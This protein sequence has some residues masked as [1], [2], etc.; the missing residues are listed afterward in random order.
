M[1]RELVRA[2]V[3]AC[4]SV[5]PAGVSVYRWKGRIERARE[6]LLVMKTTRAMVG[7]LRRAL[8]A[9]HPYEVPEF[10]V[11]SVAGGEGRYLSWVAES[12]LPGRR[13]PSASPRPGRPRPRTRR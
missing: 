1:A 12:V 4:V 6:S 7:R 8:I 5:V 3:A 11:L 13:G 9:V 2:G 10:L